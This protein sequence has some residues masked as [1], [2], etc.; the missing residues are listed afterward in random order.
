M[1]YIERETALKIIDNYAN[2]VTEDGKVIVDAIRDIVAVITPTADVA[3]V[4]YAKWG[5]S[6]N[7]YYPY[8]THCKTEPENGV[9]SKYC[10]ECG[11]KMDITP[12][13]GE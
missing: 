4:V 6:S 13:K 10:P 5:I 7:G 9:M 12:P 2:T 11:A 1:A 8:C 3:E